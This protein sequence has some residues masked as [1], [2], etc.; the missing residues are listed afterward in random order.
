MIAHFMANLC[1]F[2]TYTNSLLTEKLIES[3]ITKTLKRQHDQ[4]PLSLSFLNSSK[5]SSLQKLM[6][7]FQLAFHWKDV[8]ELF[9]SLSLI[10]NNDQAALLRNYIH[11]FSCY[12]RLFQWDISKTEDQHANNY[13]N[14]V[15]DH[16]ITSK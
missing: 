4:E 9:K 13:T 12:S 3:V 6:A 2:I 1:A 5:R 11:N 16:F 7:N 15:K 8:S 14:Y 10:D